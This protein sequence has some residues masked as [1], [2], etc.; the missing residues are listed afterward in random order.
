MACDG[1]D[2]VCWVFPHLERGRAPKWAPGPGKKQILLDSRIQKQAHNLSSGFKYLSLRTTWLH[3]ESCDVFW[4]L[5]GTKQVI[6]KLQAM[7]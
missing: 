5:D 6:H 1:G 3:I 7:S 2:H 4:I